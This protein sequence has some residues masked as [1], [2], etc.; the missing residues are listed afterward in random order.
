MNILFLSVRE[1]LRQHIQRDTVRFSFSEIWKLYADSFFCYNA[2][3][4]VLFH[5]GRF[6][7]VRC[8]WGC[9]RIFF[10]WKCA[11]GV[12]REVLK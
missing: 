8:D 6:S 2:T 10:Q 5:V 4:S 12:T 3:A 7:I 1:W 11:D 9:N